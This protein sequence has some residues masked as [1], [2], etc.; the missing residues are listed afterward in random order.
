MADH[1]TRKPVGIILAASVLAALAALYGL[2]SGTITL[3]P[4]ALLALTT[5]AE[6]DPLLHQ[7]VWEL[8]AP[9]VAAA[10][11]V[12][13]LLALAGTLMQTLVRN[14]L[15]DP[16]ILGTAGGAAAGALLGLTLFQLS[17]PWLSLTALGG[18]AASTFLVLLIAS[19][20]GSWSP[21]RLLLTGVVIATGW[22]ALISFLLVLQSGTDLQSIM[23]WLLGDLSRAQNPLIALVVLGAGLAFTLAIAPTLDVMAQGELRA[24]SLGVT[25]RRTQLIV[26]L[27]ASALTAA[28]V[29]VAGTIGFVGLITPHI[30]RL[31]G[32][33]SH[34]VIA[35]GATVLGGALLT[36]ADTASRSILA[37][38]QLPVGVITACLGV[39]FFLFLLRRGYRA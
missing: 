28:A 8:R 1:Q 34:R 6:V 37:P 15:A 2:S 20:K 23:F 25:L 16:F 11:V 7:L 30:L 38:T 14:P 21:L 27:L 36:F 35:L 10:L 18:A 32:A 33:S 39:P 19:E 26:F 31:L 3:S 22:G 29:A 12:G 24:A 17:G 9:R 4:A 13:G 5:G